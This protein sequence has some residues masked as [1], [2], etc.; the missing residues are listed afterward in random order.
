[1][2]VEV[3]SVPVVVLPV[4]SVPVVVVVVVAE[5]VAVESAEAEPLPLLS[6]ATKE[7]ATARTNNNFF[8]VLVLS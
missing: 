1:V 4:V 8:I 6:Q 7:L 5:S 2:L 3:V